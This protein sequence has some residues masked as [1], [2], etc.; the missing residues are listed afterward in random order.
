MHGLK[1]AALTA[2]LAIPCFMT[3]QVHAKSQITLFGVVDDGVVHTYQK[4]NDKGKK[5]VKNV[6][7][8]R[9][10]VYRGARWGIKGTEDLGNGYSVGFML[11]SGFRDDDGGQ[12][13]NRLF[14]RESTLNVMGPCGELY[15]GR[16]GAITSAAG[17][18][19]VAAWYTPFGSS[20]G[21][22]AVT[23]LS[24]M[25]NFQRVDNSVSYRSPKIGDARFLLQ[26]SRD[27][28]ALEDIDPDTA[29]VQH[30]EEGKRTTGHYYATGFQFNNGK[31][32]FNLGADHL[33][34]AKKTTGEKPKSSYSVTFGGSVKYD[35]LK[36]YG[37]AQV[38]W[39][40]TSA[41]LFTYNKLWAKTYLNGFA[42]V[43]GAEY[44]ILGG[45]AM[46]AAGFNKTRSASSYPYSKSTL[47]GLSLGYAYPFTK[48]T[49]I[50]FLV[51]SAYATQ[52]Y[53]GQKKSRAFVTE[54]AI[55]LTHFF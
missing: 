28:D 40:G 13:M 2:A 51:N 20:C 9:S 46:I 31:L 34:Y 7:E 44:K 18:M 4:K 22:F 48:R 42:V 49:N 23:S 33:T 35:R 12:T 8:L 15:L 17:P 27:V 30:G 11:D 26:Y 19:A 45:L 24:Y 52:K 53:D 14:G 37:G 50:Y 3:G 36:I 55:G 38:F 25:F 1:F 29:G 10:G 21:Q 47:S 32:D 5:T 54:E 16:I 6:T 43:G 39:H 41:W